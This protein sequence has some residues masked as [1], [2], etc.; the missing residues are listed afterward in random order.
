MG[1]WLFC[2]LMVLVSFLGAFGQEVR[3]QPSPS[4]T[5]PSIMIRPAGGFSRPD[6]NNTAPTDIVR[7]RLDVVQPDLQSMLYSSEGVL[8]ETLDGKSVLSQSANVGFNPA[9]AVKLATALAALK[10]YGPDHRFDTAFWTNG[11]FDKST[12]TITGNLIVSGRD[13]SFHYEHAVDIAREL[14]SLG[15]RTVTGDLIVPPKFTLNFDGSAQRSGDQLYDTLDASRRPAA[16]ARA[17]AMREVMS[18]S[19]AGEAPP[20]V[21][22]MGAVYVDSVTPGA[23][24][25][26]VHRSSKLVDILKVLLCY[27]N[28]FMA[29]RVG[30]TVGGPEG[31]RRMAISEA[32]VDPGEISLSSTS[33]LGVN[34]VT[35]RA[36]IKIF[37]ALSEVLA[38]NSLTVSDILPVAGV[39]PGTLQ[40]RYTDFRARGS[41]VAKTGTLTH[42]D[43]GASALVGQMRAANGETLRFVIFDRGGNIHASRMHQDALISMIQ[44]LRGG[45]QPFPYKPS[46]LAMRLANTEMNPSK[47]R[48]EEF[49]PAP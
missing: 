36:M 18:N 11:T 33:G 29:E 10:N 6:E 49:E 7:P 19:N 45:P 32:S 23:K 16:A 22:V 34:R 40:R 35:P 39:D 46:A 42:T 47:A 15:I 25:L 21:A 31:V 12:G 44:A 13:P 30:E 5:E 43:G 4:L 26:L 37:G 27:S 48:T 3:P 14:N 1:S 8:V 20:S 38:K 2:S 24:M 41:V 9:S 17:W 28:N